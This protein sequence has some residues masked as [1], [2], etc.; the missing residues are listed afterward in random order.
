MGYDACPVKSASAGDMEEAVAGQARALLRDPAMVAGA[1]RAI[2][3]EDA[4]HDPKQPVEK[5]RI[6]AA[7]KKARERQG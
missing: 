4:P 7:N 6:G 3:A 2:E 5:G 1:I